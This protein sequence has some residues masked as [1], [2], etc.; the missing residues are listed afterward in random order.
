MAGGLIEDEP[1][2]LGPLRGGDEASF[3]AVVISWTP[4]MI[5]LAQR[6]V[7]TREEAEGA[8]QDTWLAVIAGLDRFEGRLGLRTRVVDLIR[9][10]HHTGRRERRSIPLSA[11]RR[12]ERGPTVEA[13]RCR[14][15]GFARVAQ[16]L[17]RLAAAV[18]P[19]AGKSPTGGRAACDGGGC[20]HRIAAAPTTGEHHSRPVGCGSEEVCAMLQLSANNQRV[21]LHRARTH[22]RASLESYLTAAAVERALDR[23]CASS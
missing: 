11:A 23:M 1:M 19:D 16:R 8:V 5:V 12:E 3:T 14:P 18:G 13:V 17:V 20:H 2:L 6:F 15:A 10:A 22:V 7:A 4:Q 9:R 21:L